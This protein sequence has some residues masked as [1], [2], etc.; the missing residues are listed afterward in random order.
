M[1]IRI[2][3]L[4]LMAAL[5]ACATGNNEDVDESSAP[6]SCKVQCSCS[7][8]SDADLESCIQDVD[9]LTTE[10]R[11]AECNTE[12][13]YYLTCMAEETECSDGELDATFCGAEDEQ[14]RS[15]IHPQP[16]TKSPDQT[17]SCAY[18]YDGVCD[19]PEGTG[20][21]ANGTDAY[22]CGG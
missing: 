3:A 13:K 1:N 19:E 11:E 14:L 5:A 18:A 15:C 21:C 9:A 12:L 17:S 6:L 22:D 10:A 7:H 8:C 20:Y 16:P 4:P 2:A